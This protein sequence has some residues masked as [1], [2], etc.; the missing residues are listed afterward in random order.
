MIRWVLGHPDAVAVDELEEWVQEF[1]NPE[2]K[3]LMELIIMSY[4]EN[5]R[6]DH[7]LLVQQVPGENQRQHICAL[8]LEEDDSGGPAGDFLAAKWSHTMKLRVLAKAQRHLKANIREA[9]VKGDEQELICLQMKKRE[10]DRQL[11]DLKAGPH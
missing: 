8:T 11:E 9:M 1:E 7:S 5:G 10:I 4:R 2:L 6:L 3:G